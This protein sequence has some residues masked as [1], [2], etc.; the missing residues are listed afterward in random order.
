MA[1]VEVGAVLG[2]VSRLPDGS[3][4]KRSGVAWADL[5]YLPDGRKRFRL[6][7]KAE[8]WAAWEHFSR[9]ENAILYTS[10]QLKRIFG[11]IRDAFGKFGLPP[12]LTGK[13]AVASLADAMEVR[14]RE[15]EDYRHMTTAAD[16]PADKQIRQRTGRDDHLEL[17]VP[18][19]QKRRR[20]AGR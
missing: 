6:E 13:R 8:A 7:S 16:W 1:A 17:G 15:I 18:K 4:G 3:R 20:G 9:R 10:A 11:R 14:R 19:R 12:A 5:G 2:A